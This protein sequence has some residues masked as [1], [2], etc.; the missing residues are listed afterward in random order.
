MPVKYQKLLLQAVFF[1]SSV[2]SG[3]YLIL[4]SNSHGYLAVMKQAPPLGCIWIWSV[5]EL[6]LPW[7]VLSLLL[8]AAYLWLGDYSIY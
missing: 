6:E 8:A 1:I 7:A 3:C 2:A 4:I 5:V